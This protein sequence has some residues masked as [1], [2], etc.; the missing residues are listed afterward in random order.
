MLPK[1][2]ANSATYPV[3]TGGSVVEGK[4]TKWLTAY[5]QPVPRSRILESMHLIPHICLNSIV[6]N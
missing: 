1:P 3:V 5:I 6:L 2:V 4:V